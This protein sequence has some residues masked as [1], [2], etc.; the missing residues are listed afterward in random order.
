MSIYIYIYIAI[1]IY[2]YIYIYHWH[3]SIYRYI[4]EI[5]SGEASGEVLKS[6]VKKTLKI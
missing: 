5:D 2:I 3:I 4:C 6:V 1:Y